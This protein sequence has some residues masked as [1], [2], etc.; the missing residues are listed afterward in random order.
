MALGGLWEGW[1]SPEGEVLR[2]FAIIT[3]PANPDVAELHD[4]M[5]L[6]IEERDWLVWLGE[7]A[8]DPM[9]LLKSSPGG[10]LRV[11]SV[12]R[13]VNSPQNNEPQLLDP[14]AS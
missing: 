3:V 8:S 4:R 6:I 11:W 7:A 10:T 9:A 14:A 1:R 13:A 12:S 2:T 5:P